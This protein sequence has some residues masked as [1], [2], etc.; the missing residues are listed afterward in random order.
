MSRTDYRGPKLPRTLLDQVGGNQKT[1]RGDVSRKD[2][3]KAERQA[4]KGGTSR[5]VDRSAAHRQRAVESEEDEEEDEEE[6][7]EVVRRQPVKDAK[8]TKSILKSAKPAPVKEPTPETEV[9]EA[10]DADSDDGSE[11]SND[12]FTVSRQAAK[13]GLADEDDEIA[14]LERKL[15]IKGS[16]RSKEVGDNELEWMITGDGSSSKDE[17]K[18]V[19]RKRGDDARWLRDKRRKASGAEVEEESEDSDGENGEGIAEHAMDDFGEDEALDNPFSADEQSDDDFAGF[20]SDD[21]DDEPSPPPKRERENPYIAPIPQPT[22]AAPAP[23]GK[24][25]PPSLRTPASASSDA[26]ALQQL[27]RQL[28]GQLNRLSDANLPSILQAVDALYAT[29]ARQHV[30]STL[31]DLL[32]T[33]VSDPSILNDTFLILHAG[34]A[35]AIYRVVGTA[36]GAHLLEKVVA[37]FDQHGEA[38][39]KQQLNLIA[40]LANIY[41]LQVTSSA[42]LF[43][44][45]RLLLL[46]PVSEHTT[47]LLLRLIRTCGPQLRAE[48]PAALKDIVLSLQRHVTETE[49]GTAT[50]TAKH[51]G[52]GQGNGEKGVSVRTKYMIDAIRD[53]RDNRVRTGVAA[54]AVAAESSRTMKRVL[55]SV[56]KSRTLRA[57]EP[58]RVT[59]EDLRGGGQREGKWWLVGASYKDPAKSRPSS[60]DSPAGTR[61]RT[62][63]GDAGYDSETPGHTNLTRAARTQGMNTEVRRQIFITIVG[64]DDYRDAAQRLQG[65][66]LKGKQFV[67]EVPRVLVHCVGVEEVFNPFYAL[68]ARRLCGGKGGPGAGAGAGVEVNAKGKGQ[69]NGVSRVLGRGV[70]DLLKKLRGEGEDDEGSGDEGGELHLQKVV[71]LAKFYGALVADGT[72]G[73][74]VLK[75]G[76]FELLRPGT[77]SFVFAEVVL[78]TIFLEIG[79]KKKSKGDQDAVDFGE[80]VAGVFDGASQAPRMAVGLGGFLRQVVARAGLAKGKKEV[81][82]VKE[83]C[84]FALEA[85]RRA[86]EEAVESGGEEDED[87]D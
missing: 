2:R 30:T 17:T 66:R 7:V 48:D 15:G 57:T 84:Q 83:G 26:A 37:A 6:E 53:L 22:T 65:L 76:D 51:E 55:G 68:L 16:K 8:P 11:A 1:P 9:D 38:E 43:D 46:P 36:F 28:K 23:A 74:T 50:E 82:V 40:F 4:R 18:G 62:D 79:K 12:S 86:T 39:G 78:A 52:A 70:W 85:L 47:E 56:G 49:A 63:E 32:V 73:V 41:A 20:D 5:K 29:H 33:L 19:K 3:R 75:T 71:N 14:A 21:N 80:G 13:T 87:S 42:L 81:R 61:G 24:Y 10:V 31:V 59:L 77:K 60:T 69:G 58:L 54:S 44:Y 45:L 25:I 35:A 64:A 34:F 72:L 27:Q 67:Q